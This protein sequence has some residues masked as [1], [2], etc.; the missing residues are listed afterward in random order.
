MASGAV[1]EKEPRTKIPL[2]PVQVSSLD[3]AS[4]VVVEKEPRTKTLL[5]P[6]TQRYMDGQVVLRKLEKSLDGLDDWPK[7]WQMEYCMTKCEVTHYEEATSR[8]ADTV[9]QVE[10]C[11]HEPLSKMEGSFSAFNGGEWKVA[12]NDILDAEVGGMICE[13]KGDSIGGDAKA[14]VWEM[15]EIRMWPFSITGV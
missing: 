11:A 1:E 8:A 4:G 3:K 15:Q 10:R 13:D 7:Q 14:E 9:D 12:E 6:M 5:G 2:G